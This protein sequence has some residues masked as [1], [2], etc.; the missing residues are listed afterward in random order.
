MGGIKGIGL[1]FYS[2]YIYIY[3]VCVCVCVC[4]KSDDGDIAYLGFNFSYF[5]SLNSL[6]E[7]II[8]FHSYQ[9]HFGEDVRRQCVP[10]SIFSPT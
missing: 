10:G 7:L 2:L 5:L 8:V 9:L 1:F 6:Q 4:G 3:C